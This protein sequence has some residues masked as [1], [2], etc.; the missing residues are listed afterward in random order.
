MKI[1][2]IVITRD[3][4]FLV[5]RAE[6]VV[7]GWSCLAEAERVGGCQFRVTLDRRNGV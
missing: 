4:L 5:L 6:V 3:S 1:L 2:F 7:H